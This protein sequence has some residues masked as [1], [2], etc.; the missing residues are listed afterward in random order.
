MVLLIVSFS[1]EVGISE[2]IKQAVNNWWGI[3]VLGVEKIGKR[4]GKIHV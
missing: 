3:A 1:G 4:G 2:L